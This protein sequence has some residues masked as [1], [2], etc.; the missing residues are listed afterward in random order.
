MMKNQIDNKPY[1][2]F[3]YLK[4]VR[5]YK[6]LL[7]SLSQRELKIKYSRTFFGIGW[8]FIQPFAAVFI[9]TVFFNNFIKLDS[10]QVP[11]AQFVFSGMVCWYLFTGLLSK[12]TYSLLESTDLIT[13]VAFP[14]IILVIA[15][16]F[17]LLMEGFIL[18]LILLGT[19]VFYQGLDLIG[20]VGSLF[21]FLLMFLF[22]IS[23]AILLS[24]TAIRFRDIVH[25]VPFI[26][27]FGIWLTPVFYP[28]SIVPDQYRNYIT[29]LNPVA[30]AIEGM[31]NALFNHV[32]SGIEALISFVITVGL[33]L[34]SLVFFIRFERKIIEKI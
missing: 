2:L 6:Y 4:K 28:V 7:L 30:N 20:I 16:S 19:V 27:G 25:M 15:K 21:Y 23:L 13:K 9:Y 32:F 5:K 17:P 3:S 24:I 14:R 18:Y 12:G 11:Y 8:V 34:I 26:I 33:L 10:Q 31:R 29:Y 22:S 1:Q